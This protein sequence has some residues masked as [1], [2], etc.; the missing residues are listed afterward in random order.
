MLKHV[1][2]PAVRAR[3]HDLD[4]QFNEY[5]LDRFG[6]SRD[7]LAAFYSMLEPFYRRYFRVKVFGMEHVPRD[8]R[9]MLI[10]NHSGGVP[11]DG[12]M[13]VASMFFDHDPPRHVHGMVEKFAQTWPFVSPWFSK[14]GH[15]PGLPDNAIR[16]LEDDRLLMVFPEGAKGL[17]KLYRD[18]Y[19][20]ERFGTGFMRIALQTGTPIIPV[21]FVGGE[22]TMPTVFHARRLAKIVGAPY[23]PV[24]P[25][26][27]P[28]PMPL[29]CE[30]HFGTPMTFEGTG[31]ERDDV[32]ERNVGQVKARI[33]D[34]IATGRR[35]HK[36]LREGDDERGR[37]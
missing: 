23:W 25:Y 32:I 30:L 29:G 13:L 1:V 36:T 22:E 2:S 28:L 24:P 11:A 4:M 14:L 8:G 27:V 19:Q 9:A 10:C 18:R 33:E 17:G 15:L 35:I 6:V 12:G 5:G 31:N 37:E 21:A 34:L 20:L 3:I 7:H 26:L 16:L